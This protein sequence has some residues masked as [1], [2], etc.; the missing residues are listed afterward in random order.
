LK[1]KVRPAGLEPVTPCLEV[2]FQQITENDEFP[3]NIEL[4]DSRSYFWLIEVCRKLLVWE[5]LTSYKIIYS[6]L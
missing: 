2:R 4:S 6:R 1:I 3:S 5:A